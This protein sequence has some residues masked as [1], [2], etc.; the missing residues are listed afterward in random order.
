MEVFGL[1]NDIVLPMYIV[2]NSFVTNGYR[3]HYR[4]RQACGFYFVGTS[5][6]GCVEDFPSVVTCVSIGLNMC[7]RFAVSTVFFIFSAPNDKAGFF[8]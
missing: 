7:A 2:I 3:R 8:L 5:L 4:Q 6:I 1:I